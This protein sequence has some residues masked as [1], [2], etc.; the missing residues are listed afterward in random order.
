MYS[1]LL[2]L[3]LTDRPLQQ[4]NILET[5]EI[6]NMI[7][8]KGGEFEYNNTTNLIIGI[9]ILVIATVIFIGESN[10]TTTTAEIEYLNCNLSNCILGISYQVGET[11]YK[12]EFP[13]LLDYQR[14]STNQ[15]I[16]SYDKTNPKSCSLN[17]SN[18]NN[19]IYI[20]IG[21]G[22]IFLVCWY[23]NSESSSSDDLSIPSLNFSSKTDASNAIYTMI[24]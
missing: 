22:L 14:P 1:E 2:S 23:S 21:F 8:Q 5:S 20:L 12:N 18:Y 24:D 16:I 15:I 13:V 4:N 17:S 9:S 3:S 19:Y 11:I 6:V 10:W 7:L